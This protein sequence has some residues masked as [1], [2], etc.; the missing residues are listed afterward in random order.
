MR[1]RGPRC[2]EL[3]PACQAGWGTAGRRLGLFAMAVD[4]SMIARRPRSGDSQL[5]SIPAS[6]GPSP[7]ARAAVARRRKRVA[8]LVARA[9]SATPTR[10]AGPDASA[11][12]ITRGRSSAEPER[13]PGVARCPDSRDATEEARAGCGPLP[14]L[15]GCGIRS[16]RR[17]WPRPAPHTDLPHDGA[18]AGCGPLPGSMV[19][20]NRARSRVA[21]AARFNEPERAG[22]ARCP[23]D[24]AGAQ[25]HGVRFC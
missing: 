7:A 4:W 18:R 20:R 19:L 8:R 5:P 23:S 24:K 21:S 10:R 15:M 16:A 25:R 1:R 9:R 14:R 2:R 6:R 11:A 22:V 13:A 12:S 3:A 17:V